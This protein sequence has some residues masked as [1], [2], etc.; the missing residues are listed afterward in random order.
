[1]TIGQKD[2]QINQEELNVDKVKIIYGRDG[3]Y[4][5]A[6]R[7]ENNKATAFSVMTELKGK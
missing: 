6:S 4:Y 5:I 2:G 7:L 3:E 1:M